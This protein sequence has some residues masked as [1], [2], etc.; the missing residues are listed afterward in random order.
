MKIL[1]IV[2]AFTLILSLSGIVYASSRDDDDGDSGSSTLGTAV[3][4]GLLGGGLGAAIGSASGNAGKGALIGAGVGA[5]G[6]ALVGANNDAQKRQ[7]R[8]SDYY[9]EAPQPMPRQQVQQVQ[10]IQTQTVTTDTGLPQGAKV[11]KRVIR[12]YDAE[13][14]VVSEKEVAN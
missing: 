2:L 14:N 6:G 5:V 9:E 11:Q 8:Q 7:Q 12:T 10:P 4:G 1:R 13:G 3:M